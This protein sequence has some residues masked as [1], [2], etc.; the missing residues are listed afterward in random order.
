MSQLKFHK[1]MILRNL[2]FITTQSSVNKIIN[3]LQKKKEKEEKFSK[4]WKKN[5]FTNLK[6]NLKSDKCTRQWWRKKEKF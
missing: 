4:L 6:I 2:F 3:L 5:F 1:I